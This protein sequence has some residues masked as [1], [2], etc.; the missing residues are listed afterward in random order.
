M[1]NYTFLFITFYILTIVACSDKHIVEADVDENNIE[2]FNSYRD[3]I[4]ITFDI[5]RPKYGCIS[6]FG[7]C[8]LQIQR[9]TEPIDEPFYEVAPRLE[10]NQYFIYFIS[11]IENI[12]AV[13][14]IDSEIEIPFKLP[15]G[16]FVNKTLVLGDYPTQIEGKDYI[17]LNEETNARVIV[18]VQ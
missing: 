14:S 13:F 16:E 12:E 9:S 8:N 5:R 15:T 18:N 2:L 6:G 10:G 17:D 4:V 3:G 7:I 11:E 1:K